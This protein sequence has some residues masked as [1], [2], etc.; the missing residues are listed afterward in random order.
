MNDREN[1][2]FN[3]IIPLGNAFTTF[4]IGFSSRLV[5]YFEQLPKRPPKHVI[6]LLLYLCDW[7]QRKNGYNDNQN[8]II[9]VE[10]STREIA[11]EIGAK[12]PKTIY[13]GL[14]WLR[15]YD[16][17]TIENGSNQTQKTVITVNVNKVSQFVTSNQGKHPDYD[18]QQQEWENI[19]RG[20]KNE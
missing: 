10:V 18:N 7:T 14:Q 6:A 20:L 3:N 13:N 19:L 1:K 5:V 11:K 8:E 9:G 4:A 12:N 15:R 2:R 16:W 17:I